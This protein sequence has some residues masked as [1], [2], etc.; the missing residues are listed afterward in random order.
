MLQIF[1]SNTSS[2]RYTANR[3]LIDANN[4][5][6]FGIGNRRAAVRLNTHISTS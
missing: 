3:T 1:S 2:K 4:R 5:D 6:S